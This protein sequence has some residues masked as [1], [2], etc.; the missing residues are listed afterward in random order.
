MDKTDLHTTRIERNINGVPRSV[1][2]V[3]YVKL[4]SWVGIHNDGHTQS[5]LAAL[6]TQTSTGLA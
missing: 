3:K 1:T 4:R 5:T 2:L 6:T